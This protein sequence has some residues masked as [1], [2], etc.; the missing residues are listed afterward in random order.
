M[1]YT[2]STGHILTYLIEKLEERHD[3]KLYDQTS[4]SGLR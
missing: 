1:W 3:F 2:R 4:K